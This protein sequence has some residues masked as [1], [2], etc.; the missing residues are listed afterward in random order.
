[1]GAIKKALELRAS[2]SKKAKLACEV[3]GTAF[4][5]ALELRAP[6]SKKAKLACEV[7]GTALFIAVWAMVTGMGWVNS[8]ILPSPWKVLE[9]FPVLHFEDALVRNFAY[10]F[11]LNMFGYVEAVAF[12][13]PLGFVLGLFTPARSGVERW[14]SASRFLPL[15]AVVGVFVAWFGIDDW[16]KIQFLAFSIFIYLLPVVIQ[17]VDEVEDVYVQTIKTLGASKWQTIRHVFLPA[18][19]SR[20][21]DDIRV[22]AALSWTY[23]IVAELVNTMG[24]GIGQLAFIAGKTGRMD[25]VFAILIVIMLVGLVQDK[26]LIWLDKSLFSYK[27]AAKQGGR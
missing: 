1:M 8:G 18:V 7:L 17:R 4:K 19:T 13:I 26:I 9:A 15:T 23:I 20:V 6:L 2:L 24:G 16:M 22:L 27:Y 5:E 3:L 25:K 11:K 10:S 21:F 12:A 14:I